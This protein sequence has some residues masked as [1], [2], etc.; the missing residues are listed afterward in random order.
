MLSFFKDQV[1]CI[2]CY[3]STNFLI[4]GFYDLNDFNDLSDA[5]R[6]ADFYWLLTTCYWIL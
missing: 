6:Y 5:M 3:E 1:T 2:L 4:G